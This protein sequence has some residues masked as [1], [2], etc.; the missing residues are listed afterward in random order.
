V[1]AWFLF[2][3]CVLFAG[4]VSASDCLVGD[5]DG[6][7]RVGFNDVLHMADQWLAGPGDLP[8]L[9]AD[10]DNILRYCPTSG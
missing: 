7:C 9:T 10:L 4:V 6:D 1:R 8:E 2:L 5:V 3:L